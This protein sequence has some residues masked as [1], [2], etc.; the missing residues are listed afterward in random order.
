M[1]KI[2]IAQILLAEINVVEFIGEKEDN[3]YYQA[4]GKQVRIKPGGSVAIKKGD[5][6]TTL[7]VGVPQDIVDLRDSN[8]DDF[9]TSL[10]GW[11]KDSRKFKEESSF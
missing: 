5:E 11:L 7:E 1:R 6:W 8:I 9:R 2:A 3:T 4:N 10:T